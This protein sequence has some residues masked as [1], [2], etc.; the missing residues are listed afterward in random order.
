[1][2][3]EMEELDHVAIERDIVAGAKAFGQL[4]KHSSRSW[5]FWSATILGL[6]GLRT[7]AYAQAGTSSMTS[8][9]YRDAMRSLLNQRKYS[10]YAQMD[11]PTRS[12]CYKLMD[13]LE[14]IDAWYNNLP[15]ADRLRWQHPETILK[16]CPEEFVKGSRRSAQSKKKNPRKP[17]VS[18]ETERLKRL[19]IQVI[20]RL[21]R[22]EPEAI[23]LLD[24]IQPPDVPDDSTDDL[25]EAE[26][27]DVE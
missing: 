15:T 25:F 1:M 5:T 16:H 17:L 23:E 27:E 26:L 4:L 21:M 12:D 19:L 10:I 20:K 13:H 2:T 22:Y 8:Q 3:D 7:L 24:Q 6:R 11:N 9:A 18:V 14:E